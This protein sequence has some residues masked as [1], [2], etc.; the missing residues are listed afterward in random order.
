MKVLITGGTGTVGGQL[1]R[2]LRKRDVDVRVLTRK[3]P[4]T[5]RFSP[6]I[7][8]A[9]GDMLD[10][11][12]MEQ[13]MQGVDKLFLLNAVAAEELTQ[14]LIAVATAKK[15]KLRHITYLSVLQVDRFPDVPHFAAKL[16]VETALRDS[17]VPHSI[18]RPGYYF[19]NETWVKDAITKG[20]IY[21]MPIGTSG[22]AA[23]DVRDIAEAASVTLTAEGQ[24]GQ[25]YD[26]AGSELIT[27]PGNAATW[28]KLLGRDVQ[29]GGHDFD[30][31]ED[32]L[33]SYLP[34]W[35]AFD[36]RKMFQG[37][38]DR[39][40]TTSEDQVSRLSQL[41]GRP[42]RSY[43]EFAEETAAQWRSDASSKQ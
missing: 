15:K 36:V 38:F 43:Q 25:I 39:G 24:D 16:A 17:D 37:F 22:I 12:S 4:E 28:G 14:S 8:V 26:L 6:D 2:E 1:V 19:Q 29:Y 42:P 23:I 34:P 32:Y 31:F 9:V 41:L 20:G 21:P 33:R 11:A 27:G 30:G 40:L 35:N 3:S 10:P 13:A 5:G 18:L 7:E